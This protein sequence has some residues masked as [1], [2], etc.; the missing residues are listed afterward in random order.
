MKLDV[1]D[2]RFSASGYAFA[3]IE[4]LGEKYRLPVCTMYVS[5]PLVEGRSLEQYK[6]KLQ[7]EARERIAEIYKETVNEHCPE[8]SL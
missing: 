6:G 4:V 5:I 7:E 3:T 1:S 2:I 8:H